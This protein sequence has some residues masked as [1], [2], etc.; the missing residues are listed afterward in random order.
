MSAAPSPMHP[1]SAPPPLPPGVRPL[2]SDEPRR[3]GPFRVVGRIG[4]G[5]MGVVYAA[6]DDADR[7]VAVKCVHRV[8]AADG[9]FR[10]RFAREVALLRRVRAACVPGFLGADTR[11]EVP[12]LATEY[13]PGPTLDARVRAHG[14][15]TGAALTAFA[16]GVAE[17]L[18]AIHGAG[19]VHRDLKPGN[20]ILSPRGPRVLDFGI[21]RTVDGTALTRTGGLVGTPGWTSPEQYAGGEAT[22]RSDMFAWGGLTAFAATGRNPFGAGGTDTLVPRVLAEPPDLE[23]LP[24]ALRA[25]VERALDKDPARRPDAAAALRET[26]ALLR[27]A[28]GGAGASGATGAQAGGPTAGAAPAGAFAAAAPGSGVPPAGAPGNGATGPGTDPGADLP[29]LVARVWAGAVAPDDGRTDLWRFH[30]PPR[31]SWAR[32]NQRPLA[33]GAAGLALAVLVGTGLTALS[34]AGEEGSVAPGGATADGG[35]AT[36]GAADGAGQGGPGEDV[37]AEYRD[38]YTTGTV[39][40][41]PVPGDSAQ[42]VRT[43]EPAEGSGE[44]L[45]Q[46]RLTLTRGERF[47][48]SVTVTATAEYLPD[49]GGLNVHSDDFAW[50]SQITPDQGHLDFSRPG[51]RGVLAELDPD[52]PV[53]EFTVTIVGA[54]TFGVFYY[55]PAEALD[56]EQ[57]ITPGYP[58]GFCH[59]APNPGREQTYP[60]FTDSPGLAPHD[61]TPVDGVPVNS[62]VYQESDPFS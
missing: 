52:D 19:V 33:V 18:T 37:P 44:A 40:V 16:L 30:A 3:V 60:G 14:P 49:F 48:N 10:E 12:W 1:G 25:L 15:L 34:G 62:C 36:S 47:T 29:G 50:V 39:A 2:A 41:E 23:G 5:G 32:R 4:S 42:L 61:A 54:V 17:A 21:A 58:G 55:L 35:T 13:V 31:R 8:Y 57:R 28:P 6:L 43:L 59:V 46:L 7:R 27:A 9:G 51:S 20:V 45:E 22:D 26:A 11:A 38:L 56:E 24:G 53:A